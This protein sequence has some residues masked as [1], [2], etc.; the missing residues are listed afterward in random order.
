[1][2]PQVA[3]TPA[4]PPLD[5]ST[6]QQVLQAAYVIQQRNDR[7]REARRESD[8]AV[9]LAVIAETQELLQSQLYDVNAAARLIVGRLAKITHATGIAI[10]LIANDQ[11]TY[12]AAAGSFAALEGASE[13]IGA[14]VSEFLR[15]EEALHRTPN[16]ARSE[17]L[18]KH[19]KSPAF[20][21]VYGKGTIA[22]LLQLSF[23]GA[24]FIEEQ[25][26]RSCQLMAGLMGEAISRAAEL[27]WKQSLATER[28]TMLEALER[29]R[30]QLERLA[31]EPAK[32]STSLAA[33]A[34]QAQ[35]PVG[36]PE[37]LE[38]SI[39]VEP[40]L[41][42]LARNASVSET[43]FSDLASEEQLS[44]TC[45]N[46]GF[47]FSAGE[48]FC[49]RCGNQRGLDI[50]PSNEIPS[51]SEPQELASASHDGRPTEPEAETERIHQ[52]LAD[53]VTNTPMVAAQEAVIPFASDAPA[54][55][56]TAALAVAHQP[57]ESE[58]AESTQET[59][60][61]I[62]P[63]PEKPASASPWSSARK[64]RQW[65]HSLQPA[66]SGWVVKHSGDLSV[67]IAALVLLLV[68]FGWNVR[69]AQSKLTRSK[70]PQPSL[71]LFERMLVGLGVAEAPAAPLPLGNPNVQVWEDL[72][73]GLYYCPGSE[74]YGNTPG[75]KITNQRDAQ[76]DRFEPAAR[77][78]CE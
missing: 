43:E 5:E 16:D 77:K 68:L 36:S 33:E 23:P 45:G 37:Q 38:G 13:S 34:S 44:S 11:I 71:T 66:G 59:Q 74:L 76:L 69:P 22:A 73:T 52:L 64:A 8:A 14:S 50:S 57:G 62:V 61:E 9:T 24:D 51:G 40:L 63:V 48:K 1:V 49:G 75:G 41:S 46:C 58:V 2:Q 4:I 18:G 31:A 6:F 47:Q 56:G 42:E 53:V 10:A 29:L 72:H 25:E 32:E 19:Y 67:A 60:L 20:F 39:A 26:I 3:N 30:P 15:E 55:E 27:E 54:T 35:I 78:A 65:L 70:P 28:A 7:E 12:C 17:L 21:P